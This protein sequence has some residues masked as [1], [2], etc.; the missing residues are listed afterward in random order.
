MLTRSLAET[1]ALD[2]WR[3]ISL[4]IGVQMKLVR[5]RRHTNA[6]LVILRYYSLLFRSLLFWPDTR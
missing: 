6:G 1:V 3:N 5:R 2:T 4:F